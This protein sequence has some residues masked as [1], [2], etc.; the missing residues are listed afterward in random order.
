MFYTTAKRPWQCY[1]RIRSPPYQKKRSRSHRKE[2]V[3]GGADPKIRIY[4]V[5]NRN[6]SLDE[7]DL[8]LG[9]TIC[10]TRQVS[11]FALEAVRT[12]LN[13]RLQKDLGKDGYHI[14]VRTHPWQIYRENRM[15]A[16]AGADRLQSGMRNSFGRCIGPCARIRAGK[17]IVEVFCDFKSKATVLDALRICRYKIPSTS[18]IVALRINKQELVHKIGIPLALERPIPQ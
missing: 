9:L 5:G 17:V 15:M 11:H 18:K 16:F 7:W 8:S 10:H 4:N 6:K 2:F 14:R 13:R 12:S 3:R 1:S